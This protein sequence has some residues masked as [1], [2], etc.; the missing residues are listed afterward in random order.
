MPLC[1]EKQ[2]RAAAH[3][4]TRNVPIRYYS[5]PSTDFVLS[6]KSQRTGLSTPKCMLK[7][8]LPLGLTMGEIEVVTAANRCV[9]MLYSKKFSSI[10]TKYH[11]V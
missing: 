4:L 10:V 11:D 5:S 6:S 3:I 2:A 1:T 7:N 8:W 9:D